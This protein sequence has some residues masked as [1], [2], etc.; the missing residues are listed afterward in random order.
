MGAI[1]RA[2][3]RIY[4]RQ[5]LLIVIIAALALEATSI[6]QYYFSRKGIREEAAMR[7]ESE[8]E[9]TGLRITGVMD[10]VETAVHSNLR[11]V[12]ERLGLPDSLAAVSRDLVEDNPVIY[13]SCVALVPGTD[14]PFAPYSF[15]TADSIAT[16]QL[17]GEAY[18]YPSKEWFKVPLE[19]GEGYWS[20]PYFDTGGGEA[21]MTTFSAP[22]RDGSGVI[23]AILTADVSLDWLTELVGNLKVYPNAYSIMVSRTGRIMVSPVETLVMRSTIQETAAK[24]EDPDAIHEINRAMLSGESGN[25]SIRMNDRDNE[26]FYAPVQRAGWS[27]AIVIPGSEIYG[28]VNRIGMIVKLLQLLGLALLVFVIQRIIKNQLKIKEV[29]ERKDRIENELHIASGIQRAM[30]PK[31]YPPFPERDEVDLYGSL[32]SAKEIGGDL[33]D[34]FL[35]DEKLFFCIGDVSGKGIP[36]SLVMAVTRSLFRTVSAR[37]GEP[38]RILSQM[39]DS[40]SENNESN[41]FVTFFLGILS[42]RDGTL[43][44]CNAGHNAP[45]LLGEGRVDF[46]DTRPN[47]PL[48]VQ[49][50]MKF[51]AQ[52]TRLKTGES[53]F[54]YTDGLTEAE[55]EGLEFFG[56]ERLRQAAGKTVGMSARAQVEAVDQAIHAYIGT[57]AQ[58]DDK[59]MLAIRYLGE[60]PEETS[61]KHLVLHNDIK[62]IPQLAGF[63]EAVAQA[64]SLNQSTAMSLN[65]A[66][67]EAVTNVILYAYPQGTDGMVEIT[68]I[69]RPKK[70]IEFIVDDS[71][72]PFDPTGAERPDLELSVEDRPVGGLGIHLVRSIMDTVS[73][74][75]EDGHNILK[76]KKMI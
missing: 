6:I 43:R 59:T 49:E 15:Q 19:K 52:E 35:R 74:A 40:M 37:E 61:E 9:A 1:S 36:A 57:A 2:A 45:L 26:I 47:L 65:L 11:Q 50:K 46:L 32:V 34:F 14:G 58:S 64:G 4:A 30:L 55:N 3:R 67:E 48:G 41:M 21:L 24:L 20:E 54:L 70:E 27:M 18:D 8:L 53:I 75:R 38:D 7:A 62:Q 72:R 76:M 22:V 60:V 69:I 71:G 51:T 33:F 25:K 73:Y 42:L 31:T 68:A 56:E 17:T 10:Q 29:Q 5:G 39:N 12:R 16:V 66:L 13:G 23:R 63:I 28:N 44:Y